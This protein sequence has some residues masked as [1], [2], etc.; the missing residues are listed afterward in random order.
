MN[1]SIRYQKYKIYA[2]KIIFRKI[3]TIIIIEFKPLETCS[4][5]PPAICLYYL[6]LCSSKFFYCKSHSYSQPFYCL[7]WTPIEISSLNFLILLI[8]FESFIWKIFMKC[9]L[10]WVLW[11]ALKIHLLSILMSTVVITLHYNFFQ[12]SLS[13]SS[14]SAWF[15]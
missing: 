3:R 10:W 14:C 7:S 1:C 6:Y 5:K 11:M 12:L 4:S 13:S 2:L 8:H 15:W 9:W